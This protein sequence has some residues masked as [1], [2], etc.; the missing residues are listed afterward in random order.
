MPPRTLRKPFRAL[1]SVP[2]SGGPVAGNESLESRVFRE[3][4]TLEDKGDS[5]HFVEILENV[6][7]LEILKPLARRMACLPGISGEA[8]LRKGRIWAIAAWRGAS[9]SLSILK[10]G[11]LPDKSKKGT[12]VLCFA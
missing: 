1:K 2:E 11:L 8:C 4:Q 12:S 9:R 6:E 5:D 10:L 7:I 3:P